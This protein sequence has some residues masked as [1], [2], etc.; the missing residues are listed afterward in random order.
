[1]LRYTYIDNIVVFLYS[2]MTACQKA[3]T[4]SC[5]LLNKIQLYL[6]DTIVG[7]L[8]NKHKE[9]SNVNAVHDL[10][11]HRMH[12]AYVLR[13]SQFQ[14]NLCF[15]H[16]H[17]HSYIR[18][19]VIKLFKSEIYLNNILKFCTYLTKRTHSFFKFLTFMGPCIVRIFQYISSKMK[20]YTV[21]FIWKLLYVFRVVTPPIIG[22]ANN[23]I[24]NIWYLSDRYC[25]LPLVAGCR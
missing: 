19:T 7:L 15:L 23:C 4:H 9:M 13:S 10:C 20:R 24:Y 6:T 8:Y 1:M 2:L 14:F 5:W 12:G 3:V 11:E 17:H 22:S 16:Q 25:Y 21:Y 18:Q